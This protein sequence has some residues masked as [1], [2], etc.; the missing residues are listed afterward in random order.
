MNESSDLQRRNLP[1]SKILLKATAVAV[2]VAAVVLT[3][4]ILP[5]EYGVDPTG[6]GK[7]LGLTDMSASTKTEEDVPEP[8]A[9]AESETSAEPETAVS[10]VSVL[11]A[12][13]KSDSPVRNDEMSLTLAPGEGAEI[14]ARMGVG[15]RFVF[16]WTADGPVNFD[17]HGEELNAAKDEFTSYWKGRNEESGSGAFQAPFAGTHGW[18][19]RNRGSRPVNVRVRTSGFYGELFKP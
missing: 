5:A 10:P 18:Y 11:D 14:K 4:F 6:I 19:W 13:W 16:T 3:L 2:V 15:D 7:R 1:S 8:A 12:V 9:P 17:M